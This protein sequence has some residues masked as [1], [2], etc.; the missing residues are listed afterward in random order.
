VGGQ[1]LPGISVP[2]AEA[3]SLLDPIRYLGAP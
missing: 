1:A 2:G 3:A